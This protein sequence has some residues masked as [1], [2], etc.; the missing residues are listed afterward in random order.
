MKT[1][2]SNYLSTDTLCMGTLGTDVTF[3][4]GKKTNVYF[5]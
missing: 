2:T 5:S 4:L 3:A 1:C